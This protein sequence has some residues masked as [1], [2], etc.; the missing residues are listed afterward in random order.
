M[1]SQTDLGVPISI[2]VAYLIS[3]VMTW[4]MSAEERQS[5]L[6]ESR[7]DWDAMAETSKP[8]LVLWRALRGIPA[9]VWI[10]LS[11]RD[12][13]ALPAGIAMTLV[14]AGS[15]MAGSQ[16]FAYPQR[17]RHFVM[18]TSAG[19]LLVG[20]ALVRN[21]RSIELSRFR[22]AAAVVAA[23]F[24]GLTV[25]YP[26][27][28]DWALDTVMPKSF[29]T[30]YAMQASFAVIALGFILLLVASFAPPRRSY[31][32]V[33]GIVLMVGIGGLAVTLILWGI[34]AAPAGLAMTAASIVVG[35]A[36]LSLVHVLPRLRHLEISNNTSI[37]LAQDEE[38][39]PIEARNPR[40]GTE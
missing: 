1:Q 15:M 9:A 38:G 7:A 35:L 8:N 31:A 17:F 26:T 5:Y 33:V 11:D 29:T 39:H 23:G 32:T 13:T 16:A 6:S 4:G 19:M 20:I 34:W 14:G 21:P 2:R 12:T 28:A 10:R 22:V 24:V 30:D 3:R 36:A 27:E 18:V 25:Q 37:A 40:S